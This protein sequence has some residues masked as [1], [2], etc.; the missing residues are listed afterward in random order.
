MEQNKDIIPDKNSIPDNPYNQYYQEYI[1]G[2]EE[3]KNE[4][5]KPKQVGSMVLCGISTAWVVL[6]CCFWAILYAAGVDPDKAV[7]F[8]IAMFFFF[9]VMLI[10]AIIA[11]A[12]NRK[13]KWAVICIICVCIVIAAVIAMSILMPPWY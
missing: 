6:T 9:C 4:V 13:S 3:A 11:K 1:K 5:S 10:P 12:V 2:P 7:N 8:G